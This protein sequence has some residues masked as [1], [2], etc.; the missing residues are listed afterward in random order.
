MIEARPRPRYIRSRT[1][2]RATR[3]LMRHYHFDAA[4][5][6]AAALAQYRDTNGAHSAT[7]TDA[8]RVAEVLQCPHATV[9]M[10]MRKGIRWETADRMACRLG[11]HPGVIWPEWWE[12]A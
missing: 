5:L 11:L 9:L 3:A 6:V 2:T 12:H 1:D 4:P 7:I 8:G 10:W